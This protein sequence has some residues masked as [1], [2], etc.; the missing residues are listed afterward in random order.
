M[1]NYNVELFF[2]EGRHFDP[3]FGSFCCFHI[4]AKIARWKRSSH[5]ESISSIGLERK[6]REREREREKCV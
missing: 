5:G 1:P 3:L 6:E 2:C 4:I